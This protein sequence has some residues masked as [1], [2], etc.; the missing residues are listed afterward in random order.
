VPAGVVGWPTWAKAKACA[1]PAGVVGVDTPNF[2]VKNKLA[3]RLG[4]FRAF[5]SE[6]GIFGSA[7]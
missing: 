7:C 1:A 6:V 5:G 2:E 3:V 4:N